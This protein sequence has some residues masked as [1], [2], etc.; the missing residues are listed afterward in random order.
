MFCFF[1][2][3]FSAAFT[4]QYTF[5]VVVIIVFSIFIIFFLSL[6]QIC[7]YIIKKKLCVLVSSSFDLAEEKKLKKEL[8]I[9]KLNSIPDPAVCD[10]RV[11]VYTRVRSVSF[12]F[13]NFFLYPKIPFWP[14]SR[15][16]LAPR[17][18]G[19][20][21]IGQSMDGWM[22]GWMDEWMD[23]WMDGVLL[24]KQRFIFDVRN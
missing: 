3:I 20:L 18:I 16:S 14:I 4:L 8:Q 7:N 11:N 22:D 2:I 15:G 1:G 12:K 23:G 13:L 10:V 19:I 17:P 24:T 6:T 21:R 9:S 5:G